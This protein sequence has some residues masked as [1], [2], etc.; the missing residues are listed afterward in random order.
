MV[1]EEEAIEEVNNH[2]CIYCKLQ[3]KEYY[4]QFKGKKWKIVRHTK[5]YMLQKISQSKFPFYK[6]TSHIGLEFTPKYHFNL[7]TS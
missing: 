6:E 1:Y 2:K 5:K 7:I 4:R 3:L